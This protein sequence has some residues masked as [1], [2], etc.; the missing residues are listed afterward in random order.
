MVKLPQSKTCAICARVSE[1]DVVVTRTVR[2]SE[3]RHAMI[4]GASHAAPALDVCPGCGHVAPEVSVRYP[5]LE[6][7]FAAREAILSR[8]EHTEIARRCLVAASLFGDADPRLEGRWTLE[9]AWDDE[10]NGLFEA[11][12]ELR[13]RAARLLE[14]ALWMG[15]ALGSR[16]RASAILLSE[17][18]RVA[19]MPERA[20][21]HVRFVV[22]ASSWGEGVNLLVFELHAIECGDERPHSL[23]HARDVFAALK[24]TYRRALVARA[25][26]PPSAVPL[27]PVREFRDPSFFAS[28]YFPELQRFV[29]D[30][31]RPE[32]VPDLLRRDAVRSVV[33]A[34][35]STVRLTGAWCGGDAAQILPLLAT[36]ADPIVR[37][38]GLRAFVDAQFP[39]EH[40]RWIGEGAKSLRTSLHDEDPTIVVHAS[41]LLRR[42]V[43][44]MHRMEWL[45]VQHEA[46]KARSTAKSPSA[47]EALDML[48]AAV[49]NP[50]EDAGH[51]LDRAEAGDTTVLVGMITIV[52]TSEDF[53]H[54]SGAVQALGAM[55]PKEV[56]PV[57]LDALGD[58]DNGRAH[59]LAETPTVSDAAIDATLVLLL[60]R[61]GVT[62]ADVELVLARIDRGELDEARSYETEQALL[63]LH[64]LVSA[65]PVAKRALVERFPSLG[66]VGRLRVV[67]VAM[68]ALVRAALADP[69]P[70][71]RHEE[72]AR[73]AAIK[74]TPFLDGLLSLVANEDRIARTEVAQKLARG[75]GEVAPEHAFERIV[76][77]RNDGQ[78]VRAREVLDLALLH[79]CERVA[80]ERPR[81]A[82]ELLL[83]ASARRP[84]WAS[85]PLPACTKLL[86]EGLTD[87]D[88][89][90]VSACRDALT[91]LSPSSPLPPRTPS[92][93][94]D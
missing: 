66:L 11:A 93:S 74:K 24:P 37:E 65:S 86:R 46:E 72:L 78:S 9:A 40:Q 20:R 83:L 3:V 21:E 53:R 23:M 42:L 19:R 50:S 4:D 51:L 75:I 59:V 88:E 94:G 12:V 31:L 32:H 18:Y 90:V 56:L 44:R 13:A 92:G 34:L 76:A 85:S 60:R 91:A 25:G 38:R 16:P 63:L 10:R 45:F 8:A 87:R 57:L 36:H 69:D 58:S 54:R 7:A 67:E 52:R 33:Q 29:L 1:F 84:S 89:S 27:A 62:E 5:R 14:S 41:T 81:R 26:A 64:K 6:E 49:S 48:L 80:E 55:G 82:L 2:P 43:P 73:A 15:R 47:E 70:R 28:D 30:Y 61:L 79:V 35:Q 71:V 17:C 22:D 68:E 39:R 77:L